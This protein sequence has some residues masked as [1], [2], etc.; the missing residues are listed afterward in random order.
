M[1]WRSCCGGAQPVAPPQ[2][3]ERRQQHERSVPRRGRVGQGVDLGH[4]EH[5]TFRAELFVSSSDLAQVSLIL[6]SRTAVL[7]IARSSRYALT[8]VTGPNGGLALAR[9]KQ[10]AAAEFFAMN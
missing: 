5:W 10:T 6:L 7:K 1:V 4:T 9:A 2:V 3:A 8:T